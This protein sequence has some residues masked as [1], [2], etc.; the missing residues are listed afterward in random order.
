M[1][2]TKEEE[3]AKHLYITPPNNN[4]AQMIQRRDIVVEKKRNTVSFV[5]ENVFTPKECQ[6]L[7]ELSEKRGYDAALLNVGMW[8]NKRNQTSKNH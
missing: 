7:I 2:K 3:R 1:R 8:Y 6:E 4:T 5:L